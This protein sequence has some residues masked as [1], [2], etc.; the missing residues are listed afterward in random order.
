MA[1]H[2]RAARKYT[3]ALII[4]FI[5]L[6]QPVCAYASDQAELPAA[7]YDIEHPEILSSEHLFAKAAIL[8]D[9]ETGQVILEKNA[10]EIMHPASTTKIMTLMLAIE[11]GY[12]YDKFNQ[13]IVIPPEARDVPGDSALTPVTVHDEMPYIDLLYGMMLVSGNDAANAIAVICGGNLNNFVEMMNARAAELGMTNTRFANPHGYTAPEHYSTARDLAILSREAMKDALFRKIV[14]AYS[15]IINSRMNGGM[16]KYNTNRF[17]AGSSSN[18]YKYGTGI[19]TG[20]TNAAGQCF[21][22]SATDNRGVSLISVVLNS[23]TTNKEAKWLDTTRLM[24]YGF[25]RYLEFNFAE[26]YAKDPITVTIANASANDPGGGELALNI[27][28]YGSESYQVV[29]Y[30]ENIGELLDKFQ[31]NF[32]IEYEASAMKAPVHEGTIM[33]TLNFPLPNG[34]GTLSATLIAA[35][36]VEAAPIPMFTLWDFNSIPWKNIGIAVG[37]FIAIIIAARIGVSARRRRR[38]R[39]IAAR[40]AAARRTGAK[41]KY[42]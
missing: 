8:V 17:A 4:I 36:E 21:V 15:H 40:K 5:F 38:R 24:D 26:L 19:K 7:A 29:C 16:E 12:R 42:G 22:G 41:R 33:G 11:F 23:T 13:T 37:A 25:T 18:R 14:G 20:F 3:A 39:M 9:Q 1:P 35:R 27:F 32:L 30:D 34:T 10:D 2:I 6:M 28:V 31:S